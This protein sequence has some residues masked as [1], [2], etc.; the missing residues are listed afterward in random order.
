M[1]WIVLLLFITFTPPFSVTIPSR[2]YRWKYAPLI[3]PPPRTCPD[4]EHLCKC[5]WPGPITPPPPECGWRHTGNVQGGGVRLWMSKSVG[6]FQFFGG[7]MTTRGQCPEWGF[8]SI[9]RRADD[10]TRTMSKGG[11]VLVNVL[12]PPPLQEILYP[13][14]YSACSTHPS[15]DPPPPHLD[16]WLR[17]WLRL[18]DR[19]L[20]MSWESDV[21]ANDSVL[22]KCYLSYSRSCP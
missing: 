13:R 21:D 9:F 3:T 17:V 4:T 8:F 7:R 5:A 16:C 6:V 18:Y 22:L 15:S 19:I 14:L 1:K 11:G 10:V 2:T 12:T 20:C